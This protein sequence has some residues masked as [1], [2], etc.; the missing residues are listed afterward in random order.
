MMSFLAW[1][2]IAAQ[3]GDGLHPELAKLLECSR[4]MVETEPASTMMESREVVTVGSPAELAS[5]DI[6]ISHQR[7]LRFPTE[8]K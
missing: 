3:R 1:H 7:I 6:V 5:G 4:A 2:N 8:R